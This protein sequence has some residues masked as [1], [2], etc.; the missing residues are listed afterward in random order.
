MNKRGIANY[1][2]ILMIVVLLIVV[3]LALAPAMNEIVQ[4]NRRTSELN[5]SDTSI[6]N[7]KKGVC[8]ETDL[9]PFFFAGCILGMVGLIIWRMGT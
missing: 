7:F 8:I 4:E 2:V 3:G 6:D 1:L 9:F 5:C